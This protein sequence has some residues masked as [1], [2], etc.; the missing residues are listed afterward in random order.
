MGDIVT[1]SDPVKVRKERNFLRDFS[2]VVEHSL[3]ATSDGA[4]GKLRKE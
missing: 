3:G 2:W 4:E 1:K